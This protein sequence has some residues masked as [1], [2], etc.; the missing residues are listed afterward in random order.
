MLYLRLHEQVR[1][2]AKRSSGMEEISGLRVS[3]GL[4]IRHGRVDLA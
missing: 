3:D 1:K 4:K 2:R